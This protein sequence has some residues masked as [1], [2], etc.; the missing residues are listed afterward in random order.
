MIYNSIENVDKKEKGGVKIWLC[1]VGYFFLVFIGY[2]GE[3]NS[4]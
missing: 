1:G 4:T 3:S 2:R